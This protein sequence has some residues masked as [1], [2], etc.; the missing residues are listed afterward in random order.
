MNAF[1][2]STFRAPS[3]GHGVEHWEVDGLAVGL[4]AAVVW[5][6]VFRM[7]RYGWGAVAAGAAFFG[8]MGACWLFLTSLGSFFSAVFLSGLGR[9]KPNYAPIHEFITSQAFYFGS[10]VVVEIVL[11]FWLWRHHRDGES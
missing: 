11:M 2:A 8:L 6:F 9:F 10:L 4:V 7:W 5:T 1:L 3:P